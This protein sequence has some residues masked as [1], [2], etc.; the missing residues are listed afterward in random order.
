MEE[1]GGAPAAVPEVLGGV[2]VGDDEEGDAA[3]LGSGADGGGCGGVVFCG[4]G[5]ERFEEGGSGGI[6]V[7]IWVWFIF[8]RKEG[9][10]HTSGR[11]ARSRGCRVERLMLSGS[12]VS[13]IRYECI[14]CKYLSLVIE[15]E[16]S[17]TLDVVV[18]S[19]LERIV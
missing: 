19:I 12:F 1:V 5:G 2:F 14:G 4:V 13:W 15:I 17:L 10:G 7:L 8:L 18:S 3:G 16:R 9:K 11:S 6:A